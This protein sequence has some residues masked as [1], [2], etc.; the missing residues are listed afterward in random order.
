MLCACICILVL[1]V[2]MHAY[3]RI[4]RIYYTWNCRTKEVV[5]SDTEMNPISETAKDNLKIAY[6]GEVCRWAAGEEIN[7]WLM[8]KV[9]CTPQRSSSNLSG[10]M[11]SSARPWRSHHLFFF[12]SNISSKWSFYSF[13][14]EIQGVDNKRYKV[15]SG[16]LLCFLRISSRDTNSVIFFWEKKYVW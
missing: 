3:V 16:S 2:I 13:I 6:E 14:V 1:Y 5:N 11:C 10:S 7:S 15:V 4:W 9:Y 12:K 8:I